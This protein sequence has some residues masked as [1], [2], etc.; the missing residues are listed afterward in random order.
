MALISLK[1]YA[2]QKNISYEAVRQQVKRY[3]KELGPHIIRDGRQQFLDEEAVAFLDAKRQ[4]NPVAIIQ[5]SK[6]DRI[7]ELEQANSNLLL[8]IA[9]QADKIAALAEWKAEK[10]MEIAAADQRRLLL[11]ATLA[12]RDE[13]RHELDEA[14]IAQG[15]LTADRDGS[16]A[17]AELKAKEAAEAKQRA[18]EAAEAAE[19]SA[20]AKEAWAQYAADLEAYHALGWWQRRRASKPEPPELR[21]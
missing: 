12:E 10:A 14:R 19:K 6:D 9:E 7:D 4:K 18:S 5:Q 16:R 21:K 2:E 15:A 8:K 17:A 20:A 3:E 1:D 13:L 11:E